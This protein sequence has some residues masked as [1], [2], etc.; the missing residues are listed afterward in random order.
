MKNMM[1]VC[2]A[3][4]AFA[5]GCASGPKADDTTVADSDPDSNRVE[6]PEISSD[7]FSLSIPDLEK[8][9][10]EVKIWDGNPDAAAVYDAVRSTIEETGRFGKERDV[11]KRDGGLSMNVRIVEQKWHSDGRTSR[12]TL[13]LEI[14][15]EVTTYLPLNCFLGQ[16][17]CLGRGSE[18]LYVSWGTASCKPIVAR[19]YLDGIASAARKALRD[20][21]P[22][23]DVQWFKS[24]A[25][26]GAS[27]IEWK[28]LGDFSDPKTLEERYGRM[29]S[30]QILSPLGKPVAAFD[31]YDK[32]RGIILPSVSLRPPATL[33]DAMLFFQSCAIPLDGSG[34]A[35]LFAVFPAKEG[36]AYPVVPEFS[37]NNISLLDALKRVTESVGAHIDFRCD[38]VVSVSPKARS[39]REMVEGRPWSKEKVEAR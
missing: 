38:G 25:N 27:P 22:C 14:K 16:D 1:I 13:F 20:L 9:L 29:Y 8:S 39:V 23:P 21:H 37:A 17:Q 32:M 3:A 18:R 30:G 31:V 33:M 5:A 7:G 10:G 28:A 4:A 35:V 19:E 26:N 12:S 24:I 6:C 11:N 36:D 2:A 34:E 15:V